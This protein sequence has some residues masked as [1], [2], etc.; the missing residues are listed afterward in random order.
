ML[1]ALLLMTLTLA[2]QVDDPDAPG[3]PAAAAAPAAVRE[4]TLEDAIRES[5]TNNLS[6]AGA[7]LQAEASLQGF[8][9]AWGDFDTTFFADA[10]RSKNVQPPSAVNFS[11]PVSLGASGVTQS[12][13]YNLS[14]GLRGAWSTGTSWQLSMFGQ[15]QTVSHRDTHF[16]NWRLSVTHPLLKGGAD[17]Y[18]ISG[19]KL[20]AHDVRIA[21][22]D[23]EVTANTTIQAVVTAYWNLVYARQNAETRDLSVELAAELLAIT[24]RK[25]EQGLQ[26]RIDVI[27]A[28]AEQARRREEQLTA[29]NQV[30]QAMDDLRKL[31]FAPDGHQAW[32]GE[33][34]PITDYTVLP[35]NEPST[36]EAVEL[37][38][39]RRPDVRKARLEVERAE[40]EI[41]RAENDL[42]P[43]FDV[44]GGV[45]IN[46]QERS[47][48][49]TLRELNDKNHENV[50]LTVNIEVPLG[51]RRSGY[52]LRRRQI[53]RERA[54][55]S[56]A[57]AELTAVADV[58]Q[59]S[60]NVSLQRARVD[61][62]A[63]TTRLRREVYEGEKRRL[64][65]DLS[66][67][68][69]V[70]QSQRDLLEAIDSELR[71][72]L[73]LAVA[74]TEYQAAMGTLLE[75]FGYAHFDPDL[76]LDEMPPAYDE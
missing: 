58:R 33:L 28:E 24:R 16:A 41:T 30:A 9:A 38:L 57:D 11:G 54:A 22:L 32:A 62:T 12:D 5:F 70:R 19:V 55:V 39:L 51:N 43:R 75:L 61:A 26:N 76:S 52:T 8:H 35:D 45:G 66:T 72:R 25:F 64:E 21:S 29:H 17:D 40:I 20:A 7:L 53:D 71:A 59:S 48:S 50:S 6:L 15:S 13:V 31:V 56:R 47:P 65:N 1:P 74:H 63:E 4:L 27:E 14:T 68:F 49:L 67:P 34:V 36:D 69:Q 10:T 23:S 37:A 3:L 73:D 2:P 42:R 60:R 44:T 18:A 46:A